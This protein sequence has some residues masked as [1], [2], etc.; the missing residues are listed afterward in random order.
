MGSAKLEGLPL[1]TPA[2]A[3][4]SVET[5]RDQVVHCAADTL[6]RS[7]PPGSVNCIVTSPPYFGLRSYLEDGHPDKA[8]EIGL[9]DT[10]QAYVKRLVELF[11]LARQALRDDGVCWVNLGDSYSSTP[12]GNVRGVSEHS[13]LHGADSAQYRKTL[14]SGH[15][16]KRDT[17]R[18]PGL[19]PKDLIG[20][21]WRVAFALQDDGWYLR[22][23]APWVKRSAMPESVSDRPTSAL[24]YMFLFSKSARYWYDADAIRGQHKRLW[25]ANN[26][27]TIAHTENAA[28]ATQGQAHQGNNH[29]GKYPLPNPN[30]R[31]R[32]NTDWYFDALNFEIA[33]LTRLRDSGGVR[34]DENGLPL[35]FDINPEPS[36]FPHFAMFPQALVEPC[37]L[38]GCPAQV[39]SACGAPW[40]R[41]ITREANYEKRQHRG[42]PNNNPPMVDSSGWKPA[43]V[44]DRG[45]RPTCSCHA[46][47]RPGIALDFFMGL[48][49]TALVAQR[50]GRH[51]IGCDLNESYVAL[52]NK[53]LAYH[54]DDA[55]L[56]REQAAGVQQLALF[57]GEPG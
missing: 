55:R 48:G 12:P 47:A 51:Y 35:A 46:P 16:Q 20:I 36:P 41:D 57:A 45:F 15:A 38:A 19:K 8:A 43:T 27:G 32:R 30:G 33:E 24:E 40:E 25:D 1:M 28:L 50:L 22:S 56:I 3:L 52:A 14:M 6:L 21:P 23:A 42:Q 26:G 44:T 4:A 11:R 29:K 17:S 37:L 54:G 7:L 31:N 13:G 9:E 49:T 10:P 2:L 39:C 34:L 53:R 18:L 5:F